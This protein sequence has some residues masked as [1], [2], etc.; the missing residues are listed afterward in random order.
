MS[1]DITNPILTYLSW[2]VYLCNDGVSSQGINI[3]FHTKVIYYKSTSKL[4]ALRVNKVPIN[5][6]NNLLRCII[7]P[8]TDT[9]IMFY[10]LTV[11]MGN[12]V[13]IETVS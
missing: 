6:T 2:L 10:P 12:V 9:T 7:T 4:T 13:L 1:N 3:L 11:L 5:Y 8:L